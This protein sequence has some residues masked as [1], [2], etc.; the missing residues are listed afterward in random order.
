[1]AVLSLILHFEHTS[2]LLARRAQ[3]N[4]LFVMD[5]LY[6]VLRC[7]SLP[8]LRVHLVPGK[9]NLGKAWTI[10]Q[11][12]LSHMQAAKRLHLL[13]E[14]KNI[15]EITRFNSL[16]KNQEPAVTQSPKPAG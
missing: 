5:M 15:A 8:P 11:P 1:M 9:E 12:S 10:P 13:V 14:R 16:S 3:H 2:K 6:A 4:Q 7:F